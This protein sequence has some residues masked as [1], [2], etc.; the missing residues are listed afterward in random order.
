MKI[1]DFYKE[2]IKE[3]L[4]E[5]PEK[6]PAKEGKVTTNDNQTEGYTF[7]TNL[8]KLAEFFGEMGKIIKDK[9]IDKTAGAVKPILSAGEKLSKLFHSPY[10][11]TPLAA[12]GTAGGLAVGK[13]IHR[14]Q[15][16]KDMYDVA[17]LYYDLGA[18]ET[19]KYLKDALLYSAQQPEIADT[20][21]KTSEYLKK[22][23]TEL[24][25]FHKREEAIKV[26]KMMLDKG[27][28]QEPDFLEKVAELE[29]T[30]DLEIIQKAIEINSVAGISFGK[31]AEDTTGNKPQGMMALL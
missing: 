12:A 27:L 26:A 15:A 11:W 28:V 18:E 9:E 23:A 22:T 30:E 29:K 31:V 10:F 25:E 1:G 16:E 7:D 20:I 6:D 3:A 4:I 5:S 2:F 13:K 21:T 14:G 17:R 8:D 24:K 19:A